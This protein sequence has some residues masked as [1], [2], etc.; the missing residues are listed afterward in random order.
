MHRAALTVAA[1][2][3]RGRPKLLAISISTRRLSSIV[4]VRGGIS[5]LTLRVCSHGRRGRSQV[6][7]EHIAPLA[8]A[9]AKAQIEKSLTAYCDDSS[10]SSRELTA[11]SGL[12]ISTSARL[13]GLDATMPLYGNK[14]LRRCS[15]LAQSAAARHSFCG[16]SESRRSI[17]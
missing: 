2:R 16:H 6:A 14:R 17:S 12:E 8:A 11:S 1:A 10:L 7:P 15:C 5:D 9:P 3:H 4:G 13:S